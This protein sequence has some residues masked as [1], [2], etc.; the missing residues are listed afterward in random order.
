MFVTEEEKKRYSVSKTIRI[1]KSLED[2][3][4]EVIKLPG[5]EDVTFSDVVR[6]ALSLYIHVLK[7]S[8]RYFGNND[9]NCQ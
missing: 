6:F 3:V 5:N 7:Y 1:E 2:Q 4:V 9:G 8:G